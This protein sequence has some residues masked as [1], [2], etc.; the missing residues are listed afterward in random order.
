MV[1]AYTKLS[2]GMAWRETEY[3]RGRLTFYQGL[4]GN[5]QTEHA[6]ARYRRHLERLHKRLDYLAMKF[7]QLQLPF[8]LESQPHD[9]T[10]LT[11]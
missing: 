2:A 11:P 9:K 8:R 4:L 1:R 10:T 6:R 7:P 5:A 3:M